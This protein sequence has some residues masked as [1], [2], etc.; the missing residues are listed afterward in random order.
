[1]SIELTPQAKVC[2]LACSYCYQQD[3]REA[4][5]NASAPY[6]M[7]A[8]YE[9]LKAEGVGKGKGFTLFGGE[10]LLFPLPDLERL[11]EWAAA[12]GATMGVQTNGTILTDRHLELFTRFKVGVGVSMDGPEELNDAREAR[13]KDATRATT[14]LS[15]RNLERML[16][17]G[18]SV[19]LIVT[20]HR[21]N[22]G[23]IHQEAK[24]VAWL[25]ALRDRGLR[26]VNLHTLEPHGDDLSLT[27][28]RQ[29]KVMRRLRRVLTGFAQVSPFGDMRKALLQESGSNCIWNFCVPQDTKA[30]QGVDGQGNRGNCGRTNKDGVGYIKADRANHARQLALFLTPQADGGCAECRF[31]VPCGGGNCPGEG[32]DGD[33]RN[34]TVHCETIK[35]MFTD[36]EQE[37]FAEGK[38]PIS[39]SLRRPGIEASLIA[40]WTGQPAASGN[41]PHGDRQ[42]GDH[43]DSQRPVVTDATG[44]R[45]Q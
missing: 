6:D 26:Y 27:Q 37:L 30:V 43:T 29:T 24:L 33:M 38:E 7:E 2:N 41:V 12:Q 22:A 35:A 10:A 17:A 42:H 44:R 23:T 25:L 36:L 5:Q 28:D 19:S 20:L 14:A 39:M 4:T 32:I 11:L 3:E 21:L 16:D 31:F 8:M 45:I 9:A 40:R 18:L 13:N 1:L 34:R 15:Q